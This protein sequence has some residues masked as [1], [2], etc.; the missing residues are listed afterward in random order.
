LGNVPIEVVW[1]PA[2]DVGTVD[3]WSAFAF[4]P[5]A[6]SELAVVHCSAPLRATRLTVPPLPMLRDDN[7]GGFV[8]RAL[9]VRVQHSQVLR[10][11]GWSVQVTTAS[12]ESG[13]IPIVSS[14]MDAAPPT[15]IDDATPGAR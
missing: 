12:F 2:G 7:V 8:T 15:P 10:V 14:S 11:E 9:A 13:P 6:R 5:D 1:T 4:T 3:V